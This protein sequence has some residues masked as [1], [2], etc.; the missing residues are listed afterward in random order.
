MSLSTAT[1]SSHAALPSTGRA[2]WRG[3]LPDDVAQFAERAARYAE[4]VLLLGETGS[5]KTH[6]ATMIHELSARC[7]GPCI[8]VNCG[9][10]PESLFER[11]MFGHVRGAFT[12]AREARE[13]LFEAA[14]GGTLF[15]DEV[16]EIPLPM[17]SKLLA[18][19]EENR[20]RR[21]GATRDIHVDVRVVAATNADLTEM[22]RRKA[23]R[24]DLFHR[25][26]VLRFKIPPLRERQRDL[27]VFIEHLLDRRVCA[28][29][30]P[31][32][33]KEALRTLRSYSWPGN[34]RELD[35]ALRYALAFM[36]GSVIEPHHLPEEVRGEGT[37][38]LAGSDDARRRVASRYTAPP[39]SNLERAMILEA[40]RITSG[41]RTQ[42]AQRLGMSRSA[43]WI[44]L[45]RYR[46]EMEL[47]PV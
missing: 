17:Q 15:L 12:D 5:G 29:A 30:M 27:P 9:A 41:N 42:A 8:R 3:F 34:I 32:V 24:E 23:F 1:A 14:D 40:L 47:D 11:E 7:T 37:L 2:A 4:P 39:D 13:G 45:Q 36:E 19:L 26:A 25:L 33:S 18:A 22:V 21:L 43:L 46:S 31:A 44:K 6:L 35:N 20:I 38:P 10:I 28:G 16:G